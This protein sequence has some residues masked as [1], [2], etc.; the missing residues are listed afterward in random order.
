MATRPR[1][2]QNHQLVGRL[3]VSRDRCVAMFAQRSLNRSSWSSMTI[4]QSALAL[5]RSPRSASVRNNPSR[6]AAE[7]G[8]RSQCLAEVGAGLVQT[9]EI[10][11]CPSPPNEV[12]EVAVAGHDRVARR[13]VRHSSS[14]QPSR[15]RRRDE[16]R[17]RG[18]RAR[19][20]PV[21]SNARRRPRLAAP[22]RAA[23]PRVGATLLSDRGAWR[24]S[25]SEPR[26][27]VQLCPRTG[28]LG[29]TQGN[30]PAG[31][32]DPPASANL[33]L[34]DQGIDRAVVERQVPAANGAVLSRRSRSLGRRHG[35]SPSFTLF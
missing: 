1:A 5:P 18:L 26:V 16:P 7:L 10:N 31:L 30:L 23:V 2:R 12:V 29:G 33:G 13:L 34:G 6:N 19:N 25:D 15:R 22:P 17:A 28:E 9:A 11:A 32:I 35:T 4:L 21:D 14:R 27:A 8:S 3:S 24:E 20:F